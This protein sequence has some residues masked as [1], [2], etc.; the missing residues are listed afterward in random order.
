MLRLK[1]TSHGCGLLA[2]LACLTGLH[3]PAQAA[4]T[5]IYLG[6]EKAM[7]QTSAEAPVLDTFSD[8]PP[9]LF[10]VYVDSEGPLNAS[11]SLQGPGLIYGESL[12]SDAEELHFGE[13]F[14]S[15]SEL[16]DGSRPGPTYSTSPPATSARTA[17][18]AGP[19]QPCR[20]HRGSKTTRPSSPLTPTKP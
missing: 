5:G 10:G 18:L 4:V 1:P 3:T 6:Q 11:G 17:A 7:I 8:E 14:A 19:P 2:A 16:Q 20:R 9:F 13:N 15:L 12:E